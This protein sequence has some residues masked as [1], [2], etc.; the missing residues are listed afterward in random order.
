VYPVLLLLVATPVEY[1]E[2][3]VKAALVGEEGTKNAVTPRSNPN[4]SAT[5]SV[6]KSKT[7]ATIPISGINDDDDNDD[8]DDDN[9][10]SFIFII[11]VNR[12][13]M[14]EREEN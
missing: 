12:Y 3:I 14:P 11:Y 8:D 4:W 9:D 6:I 7:S 1:D 13:G 10:E 2:P 5:G